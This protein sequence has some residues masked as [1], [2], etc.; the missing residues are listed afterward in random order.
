MFTS[1]HLTRQLDLIPL[2]AL[3]MPVHIIGAGAIGSHVALMLAKM[4]VTDI[5]VYDPDVVSIENM[6]CQGFRF[7][8][9]GKLKVKALFDIV[10]SYTNVKIKG[11]CFPWTK[12][13]PFD[14]RGIVVS[15][16][17][18]MKVRADLFNHCK[19]DFRIEWFIDSRMGAESA[20][21]YVMNAQRP[22][23]Q[24]AYSATLYSDEEAQ[25][26]RCTAKATIYTANLLSGH[27]VKAVKDLITKKP[28]PRTTMWNIA[29][30]TKT[31][32]EG[33]I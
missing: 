22:I 6:S 27:V 28:Y 32:W 20:L 3:K 8:D 19:D 5:S 23:D 33:T 2:E 9:I 18:S 4:G 29:K 12:E 16:A 25:P 1:S 31:C 24:E 30:N 21:M 13:K 7:S 10:E 26:E 11:Y 14:L 15:A 17:D